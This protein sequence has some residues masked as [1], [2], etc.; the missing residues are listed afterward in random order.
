VKIKKEKRT[1]KIIIANPAASLL[2]LKTANEILL[3]QNSYFC[4]PPE[5]QYKINHHVGTNEVFTAPNGYK[6]MTLK[7]KFKT[8]VFKAC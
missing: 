2:L 7:R 6:V 5:E 1:Y 4:L 3:N 8:T